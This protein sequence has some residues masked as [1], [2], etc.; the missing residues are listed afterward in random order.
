MAVIGGGVIGLSVARRAAL[1]G[2]NVRVHRADEHGASWVA[3]GMLAP[4]SEGW[5]GEE[6]LLQIGL[7]SLQMW[8]EDFLDGLPPELGRQM[9]N[10]AV[11]IEDDGPPGLL[12]L[13]EGVPLT[14][15]DEGYSGVLPDRITIYQRSISAICSSDAE[16]V[17]AALA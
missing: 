8:N 1:D 4:H 15:R 2:R 7:A 16:V 11:V 5:P 6:R 10:V 17:G 12:G 13:Y 14:E 9:R 3:G